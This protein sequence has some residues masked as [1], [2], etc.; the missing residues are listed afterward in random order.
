MATTEAPPPMGLTRSRT[1]TNSAAEFLELRSDETIGA[2]LAELSPEFVPELDRF[3]P[4][5]EVLQQDYFAESQ[6]RVEKF[7]ETLAL[8]QKNLIDRKVDK[9][10]EIEIKDA[11]SYTLEDVLKIAKVVQK[12]HSDADQ[13]HSC[14]GRLKKFFHATGRNATTFKRLLTFVPDDVYGSVICGGFTVILGTL[15]RLETL[16]TDMYMALDKIPTTLGRLHE[17]LDVHYQS[18]KLKH[19]GD[20]LLVAVF[21]LLELIVRELSGSAAKKIFKAPFR[22]GRYGYTI[23]EAIKSLEEAVREFEIEARICDSQ[24]L[25]QVD[26][27]TRRTLLTAARVETE[28]KKT[29]QGQVLLTADYHLD[30][31]NFASRQEH[32][33]QQFREDQA[34]DSQ[35]ILASTEELRDQIKQSQIEHQRHGAQVHQVFYC[36]LTSSPSFDSKTGTLDRYQAQRRLI[37]ELTPGSSF[38]VD[39]KESGPMPFSETAKALVDSWNKVTGNAKQVAENDLQQ[40]IG[41]ITAKEHEPAEHIRVEHDRVGYILT[42]AELM[43]WLLAA[44]SS[45]LVVQSNSETGEEHTS[46]SYSSA[47]LVGVIQK[48]NQFPVLHHFSATRAA[49]PDDRKL[50]GAAGLYISLITQLLDHL[51]SQG[52]NV[53]LDF[54]ERVIRH[55]KK[56]ERKT[57]QLRRTFQELVDRLP[58]GSGLFIIVD[59]LWKLQD[60]ESDEEVE[61]LLK[62][63]KSD[64][65]QIKLFVTD[66]LSLRIIDPLTAWMKKT[67]R[68]AEKKDLATPKER[69]CVLE[70]PDDV[71]GC[72]TDFN[73]AWIKEELQGSVEKANL[74]RSGSSVGSGGV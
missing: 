70:P 5:D 69:V 28:T 63:V 74:S 29:E 13:V 21:V 39:D 60:S 62:L 65:R 25:G 20:G 53:E 12:K 51:Q 36:F 15:E 19:Y 66:A 35:K 1:L 49:A 55:L 27:V 45:L 7:K 17:L 40:A 8:F 73:V 4:R 43:A 71:D 11:S 24:R 37:R 46:S 50:R 57:R 48:I 18:P 6:K 34:A 56:G 64:A 3:V 59:S 38:E 61:H 54:L 2:E 41:E 16:R 23:D 31:T 22:G 67:Q 72:H 68:R 44:E 26:I 30:L 52:H 9:K 14:M 42:S 47:L 32:F 10:Y 58:I 33:A